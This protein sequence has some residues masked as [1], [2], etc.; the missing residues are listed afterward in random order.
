MDFL[1]GIAIEGE[2]LGRAGLELRRAAHLETLRGHNN[3][4]ADITVVKK[5]EGTRLGRHESR[6]AAI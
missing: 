6:V 5:Y 2:C 1:E 3:D 4:A